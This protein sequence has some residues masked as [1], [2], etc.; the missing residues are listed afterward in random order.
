MH[1]WY[2]K[3]ILGVMLPVKRIILLYIYDLKTVHEIVL[4]RKPFQDISIYPSGNLT[5]PPHA[6]S[7]DGNYDRW[8]SPT[9]TDLPVPANASNMI[10][11]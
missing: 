6:S 11:A 2:E 5:H 3:L 7:A 1:Q 8:V 10:T 4:N 9:V